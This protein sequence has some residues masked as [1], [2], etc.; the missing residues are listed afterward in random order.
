MLKHI[1]KRLMDG[2]EITFYEAIDL[3]EANIELKALLK[4]ADKIREFYMG[5]NIVM[6]SIVNGKSGNCSE[7]CHFCAQSIRYN[8]NILTYDKMKTS[9]ILERA[10]ELEDEGVQRFSI[11]TSGKKLEEADLEWL[12]D[13]YYQIR[14]KTSL[15]LCASHGMLTTLQAQMLKEAGVKRYHHNL[16]TSRRHYPNIC[17]THEYDDRINTIL[18]CQSVGLDICSGG[19]FG[20]GE[21]H[22]DRI[23]MA[24][25]LKALGVKAVPINLLM[26]I[27]GTPL[28]RAESL[29]PE[30]VL[31]TLAI[32]R[33]ILPCSEIRYAGGRAYLVDYIEKGFRGGVNGVLTGNYLTTTG[34]SVKT[35]KLLV[36]SLGYKII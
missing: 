35:D 33:L 5:N 17:T 3:F 15:D 32:Y 10:K 34:G 13:A 27:K 16:E 19:I 20:I 26:P 8:T 23:E 31:R 2:E 25:E 7:D 9:D 4:L 18:N 11:V 30:L 24:F 22:E 36:E 28:E 12:T 1:E 29:M 6:C 21:T 14:E